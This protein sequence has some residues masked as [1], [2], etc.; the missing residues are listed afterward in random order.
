MAGV[1]GLI[2]TGIYTFRRVF[3]AEPLFK[4]YCT[5]YGRNLRTGVFVHFVQGT[6]V[7]ELGDDVTVDGKS[8]FLFASRF[9]ERPTLKIGDR[10]GIGHACMFT[11]GKRI[12]IGED[13]RI[14]GNVWMFDSPGHPS[15]PAARLTGAPP[16][17]DQV[18]PITIGRNVWIGGHSIIFPGVTIGEGSVVAAGSVVTA[19]VAAGVVVAGNPA[20]RIAALGPQ[21]AVTPR[22]ASQSIPDTSGLQTGGP[23]GG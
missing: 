18:R 15:D 4:G 11:V 8:S 5:S 13:C 10:T 9:S 3:I 6:G 16:D 19:D 12:D 22:P 21:A 14:A 1:Y 7:L 20:R 17:P 2:R 23:I